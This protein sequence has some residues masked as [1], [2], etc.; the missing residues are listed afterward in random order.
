[1]DARAFGL[2]ITAV[3]CAALELTGCSDSRNASPGRLL[4]A[5]ASVGK[6]TVSSYA[7]LDGNGAPKV[8]GIVFH[9]GA[10]DELPTARSDGHHCFDRNGDGNIDPDEECFGSHEWVIPLPSG[11]VSGGGPRT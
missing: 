6:G 10:L 5:Y 3:L 7:E 4:G 11:A 1:M 2:G 9:A 8:I